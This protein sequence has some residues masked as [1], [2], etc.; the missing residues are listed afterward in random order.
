MIWL[1]PHCRCPLE[2]QES[3]AVCCHNHSFDFAREGYLNL[4][5]ANFK[6]SKAPGDDKSMLSARRQFL[7]A[8]YYQPLSEQLASVQAE[9][10][11]NFSKRPV[12]ALDLGGGDGYYSS[13]LQAQAGD[14]VQ[15]YLSDISKEALR[16][17][18]KR[19]ARGHCVVASSFN[20]PVMDAGLD[21]VLRNFAPSSDAELKRLL[22]KQGYLVV[23]APGPEHLLELRQLIYSEPK[24]HPFPATPEGATLEQNHCLTYAMSLAEPSHR[25]WLFAMTPMVWKS[26]AELRQQ[27]LEADSQVTADFTIA[28]YRFPS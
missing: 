19:F 28:I 2:L 13:Y 16:L 8:G 4:L 6:H 7:A 24:R 9:L 12:Q 26:S 21:I 14:T 20:V 18:G 1:C 15:W 27:W 25:D 23:V 3:R 22:C 10:L 5:P 17:A 11:T